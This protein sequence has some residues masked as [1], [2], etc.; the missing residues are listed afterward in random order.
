ML[1]RRYEMINSNY[2]P[3]TVIET[4]N[5]E[6]ILSFLNNLLTVVYSH[7]GE[8]GFNDNTHKYVIVN[9]LLL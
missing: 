7:T 8:V 4:E 1:H 6:R 2:P 5:Y 3:L 9:P